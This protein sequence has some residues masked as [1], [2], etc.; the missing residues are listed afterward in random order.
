MLRK[1][2]LAGPREKSQKPFQ[3]SNEGTDLEDDSAFPDE[4]NVPQID[5]KRRDKR[6]RASNSSG[7]SDK[8]KNGKRLKPAPEL[9]DQSQSRLSQQKV[10]ES[11]GMRMK[12]KAKVEFLICDSLSIFWFRL[13]WKKGIKI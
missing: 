11:N 10:K 4:E 6:I 12:T 9:D 1:K 2:R 8:D 5:G 7:F 13:F 3:K